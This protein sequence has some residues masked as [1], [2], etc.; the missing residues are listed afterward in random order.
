MRRIKTIVAAGAVVFALIQVFPMARNN[1]PITHDVAAPPQVEVI[2][3]R[4]CY[5]CHSNETRWPWYARVA[6]ASWLVIRDVNHARQRLN[7]S[8]WDKYNDDPE[9]LITKLRHIDKAN[10]SADMPPWYY[11]S[12]HSDAHLTDSDRKVLEQ[13]T[14]DAIAKVGN[15]QQGQP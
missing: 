6:P 11:L 13:W 5:D 9:T 8:T 7:F 2:L 15:Q 3:R 14:L 12:A 4:A 1:P 10:Q